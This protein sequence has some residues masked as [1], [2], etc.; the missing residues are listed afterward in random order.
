MSPRFKRSRG[1][2]LIELLVV[3]AVMGVL[4]ALLL[5]AIQYARASARQAFCRSRLRQLG[6]GLHNYHENQGCFP[7]GSYIMG[8][9]FATQSGWGW[10]AMILP[11]IEHSQIYQQIDFNRGTA[12]GSNLALIGTSVPFWRCPADVGSK[13]IY[14][15]P[16][17]HPPLD[18]AVGNYCGSEGVLSGMSSV[19]IRDI[20]DGTSHTF[21]VGERIVQRGGDMSL[22]FTSGWFGQVAYQDGYE[23]RSLPHLLPSRYQSINYFE[24]DP[25]C[26]GSRHVG[27]ANFAL[28]DGSARFFNQHMDAVLYEAYGTISGAEVP[29]T[30]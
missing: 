3:M 29:D 17:D 22:P 23:Y 6:L 16:L 5:P 26:F 20:T 9:S 19:R 18:L 30:P 24:G 8:P 15:I 4:T 27:G 2:T 14:A 12:V 10:G 21:M 11:T 25:F 13:L 28:A 1:F 7:A